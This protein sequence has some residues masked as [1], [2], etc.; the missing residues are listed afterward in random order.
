MVVYKTQLPLDTDVTVIADY[1]MG[2]YTCDVD[3][4]VNLTE[5]RDYYVHSTFSYNEGCRL[6]VLYQEGNDWVPVPILK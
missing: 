5:P 4:A 6:G 1:D 2:N 3:I